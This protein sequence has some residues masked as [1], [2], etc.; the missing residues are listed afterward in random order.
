LISP[1]VLQAVERPTGRANWTISDELTSIGERDKGNN[2]ALTTPEA[3]SLI[4]DLQ[5]EHHG[6]PRLLISKGPGANFVLTTY[7]LF[8]NVWEEMFSEVASS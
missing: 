2:Y 6:R 7:F 3:N 1:L 5:S 4:R 8:T